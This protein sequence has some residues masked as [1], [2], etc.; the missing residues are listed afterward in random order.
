MSSAFFSKILLFGEYSII[1]NSMA[2]AIPFPLFEGTLRFR[3]KGKIITPDKDMSFFLEYLKRIDLSFPF[4]VSSFD[5]DVKRG[6][7]FDSTIP[8]GFGA[9]SSGA[10]C[11][12]LYDRYV[13]SSNDNTESIEELKK[14]FAL[15]ES[16]FHGTSSGIDP[17]ISYL[18]HG[19]LV[20]EDQS[21]DKAD[22]PDYK[23]GN[24]GIFILDTGDSR[25]TEP[26]VTLFLEKLKNQ[27]FGNMI[28]KILLPINNYCIKLFL[29]KKTDL[30]YQTFKKLSSLQLEYF[31]P[32]IPQ[33]LRSTWK[34]GIKNDDYYL[35]LC[36][37]GGGGFI[38]GITQDFE[39]IQK[40]LSPYV[41]QPIYRFN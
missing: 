18:G 39:N 35:K 6:L 12:A 28:E 24:K 1:R 29:S 40:T 23:L 22:I 30:L 26:L 11:A 31:S 32:M 25:Q 21:L 38:L 16:H 41:I 4:D 15:M 8:Q 34:E 20:Q 3:E 17:L 37:A 33:L 19:L 14:R 5:A 10:L 13:A 27:H 9:G 2:L 7:F 36:G